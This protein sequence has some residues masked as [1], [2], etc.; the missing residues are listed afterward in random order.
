MSVSPALGFWGEEEEGQGLVS[1]QTFQGA[2]GGFPGGSVVKNL[3]ASAR[4]AGDMDSVP[5]TGRPPGGGHS[6]PLQCS[7]QEHPVDR[8]ARWASVHG[9][10]KGQTCL[11]NW[12]QTFQEVRSR[13]PLPPFPPSSLACSLAAVGLAVDGEVLTV[14]WWGAGVQSP[15]CPP[16]CLVCVGRGSAPL[17]LQGL[18]CL[19]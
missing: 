12:A 3:P 5:V 14:P 15:L 16:Q 9:V 10:T 18:G 2:L 1:F 11:S 8:G 13:C 19:A 4:D 6:N 17:T 7:C